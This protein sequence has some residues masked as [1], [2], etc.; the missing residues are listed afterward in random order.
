[1]SDYT[2]AVIFTKETNLIPWLESQTFPQ[3]TESMR[4]AYAK[5]RE[6]QLVLLVRYENE[7]TANKTVT[8]CLCKIKCP[9]N[10]L[11]VKGEFEAPSIKAVHKHLQSLG[12][13]FKD[14]YPI[15]LFK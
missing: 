1:M 2:Y 14:Q 9:V 15:S 3:I 4:N 7:R 13:K 6:V 11:P 10:P 8:H 12:W 5:E